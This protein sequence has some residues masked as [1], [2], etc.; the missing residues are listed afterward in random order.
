[1]I[2]MQMGALEHDVDNDAEDSKRDA[3]L[4]NL[5]LN[6]IEGSSVLN[7]PQT[8]GGNLAAVFEEG[9]HPREGDDTNEWPV[10]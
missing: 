6:E 10:T 4:Y 8:I 2:P 5:Q 3:F 1:M 7:E 9:Y